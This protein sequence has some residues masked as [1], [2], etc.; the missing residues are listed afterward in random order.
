MLLRKKNLKFNFFEKKFMTFFNTVLKN[1]SIFNGN[2]TK[3][4]IENKVFATIPPL[5][6]FSDVVNVDMRAVLRLWRE[7]NAKVQYFICY[8][9]AFINAANKA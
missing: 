2:R 9:Y 6:A 5:L 1:Y 8:I 3:D 7:N 4:F